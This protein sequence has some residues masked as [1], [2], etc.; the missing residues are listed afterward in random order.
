MRVCV[1]VSRKY[2]GIYGVA[3]SK[4]WHLTFG[5]MDSRGL[6]YPSKLERNLCVACLPHVTGCKLHARAESQQPN[7]CTQQAP[8]NTRTKALQSEE[9]CRKKPCNVQHHRII[10]Q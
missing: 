3:I 9:P 6:F 8:A 7:I 10:S 5:G 4:C 1:Y 2:N